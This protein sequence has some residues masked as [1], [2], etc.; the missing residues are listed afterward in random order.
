MSS[1]LLLLESSDPLLEIIC[2]FLK[3]HVVTL[4]F[5]DRLGDPVV[6]V[7]QGVLL[8][9][10][11]EDEKARDLAD[12]LLEED[13][14]P[15]ARKRLIWLDFVV[16]GDVVDRFV[17]VAVTLCRLHVF[18]EQRLLVLAC[19]HDLVAD[20]FH[21]LLYVYSVIHLKPPYKA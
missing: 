7:V 20:T 6:I 3:F 2:P 11:R 14:D 8:P 10:D 18:K 13:L 12:D 4:Y 21:D 9:Y 15:V 19:P 16:I 5:A 17:E 1:A